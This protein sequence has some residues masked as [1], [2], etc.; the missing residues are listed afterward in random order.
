M[1]IRFHY[2]F[3]IGMMICLFLGI[4]KEALIMFAII[5]SHE[6]GHIIVGKIFRLPIKKITLTVLGGISEI[7]ESDN[8][9]INILLYSGGVVINAFFLILLFSFSFSKESML[10]TYNLLLIKFN[11]LPIFP[12]DGFLI[13]NTFLKEKLSFKKSFL[14]MSIVSFS[15]LA[16]FVIVSFYKKS[17]ALLIMSVFLLIKNI[18]RENEK[19]IIMIRDM[20][21]KHKKDTQKLKNS[22]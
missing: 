8:Y 12:L 22:V 1:K 4:Y 18:D 11:L 2:S 6:V 19:E 16:F 20:V 3:I 5:L 10:L 21:K 7:D 17:A 14:I 15:F 9:I 13:V